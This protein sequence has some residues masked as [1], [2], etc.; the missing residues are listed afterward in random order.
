MRC[1]E[2]MKSLSVVTDCWIYLMAFSSTKEIT[3][4]WCWPCKWYIQRAATTTEAPTKL[5][6][7]KEKAESC[8]VWEVAKPC[9]AMPY[10]E[11]L[12]PVQCS[13]IFSNAYDVV[14]ELQQS[15]VNAS[16]CNVRK[17][18]GAQCNKAHF[19]TS[20]CNVRKR[21]AVQCK[22]LDAVHGS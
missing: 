20:Q 9:S 16:Q 7:V 3:C 10:L 1:T 12:C 5:P 8:T 15:T 11:V 13:A 22:K 4:W 6:P 21:D 2:D 17:L 14:Q 19:N 18:Y